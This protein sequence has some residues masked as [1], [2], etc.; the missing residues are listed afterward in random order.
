M[1]SAPDFRP[2]AAA[3]R[4]EVLAFYAEHGDRLPPPGPHTIDTNST[5]V[6]RRGEPIVA[7]LRERLGVATLDGLRVADLGCG[8]G[9][10]A[11][12]FAAH[13][14]EVVGIDANAPRLAVGAAVA[15][16]HGLSVELRPGLLERP[17]LEAGAF[18]AAVLNNALCYLVDPADR[19]QAL[20]A[21]RAL[22]RPG[23]VVVLRNPNR[24][25]PIDQFTGLPLV[26]A[27]EP[28]AAVRAARR[29]GRDRSRVRLLSPPAARREL[30]RAGFV[31]VEHV[32]AGTG[33]RRALKLVARYQHLVAAR[34][35]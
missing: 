16:R 21:T 14:A 35:A 15:R 1:V 18:D 28:D 33:A 8:F 7:L 12:L 4:E 9:A 13:G 19:A 20:A 31:A 29:L 10:L 6:E 26:G 2:V 27:L 11:L 17:G 30:R 24:W 5:L 25:H 22:L 3:L 34:P 32:G 23:G